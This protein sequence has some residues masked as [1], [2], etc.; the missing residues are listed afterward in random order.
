M[1]A[2]YDRNVFINCPFD[3]WYQ[4]ILHAMIFTVHDCG[5]L[6]RMALEVE[7]GG[8][9]RITKIKRIIRECRYGVHDISRVE[10][11]AGSGLP[12]FDVPLELGLFL[13]AREYGSREQKTKR[14]LILDA[15]RYRYR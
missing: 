10:P 2:G 5:F 11:D 6:A 15:E 13:G 1:V 14:S 7:D 9:V 12:R 4:P 3:E 8:E